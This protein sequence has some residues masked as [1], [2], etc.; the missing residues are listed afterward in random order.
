MDDE[1]YS[2]PAP[3]ISASD[4]RK[5]RVWR[6]EFTPRQLVESFIIA[7][8]LLILNG[9]LDLLGS[10][11]LGEIHLGIMFTLIAA[12]VYYV[13]VPVNGRVGTAWLILALRWYKGQAQHTAYSR[14]SRAPRIVATSRAQNKSK[15]GNEGGSR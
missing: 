5:M 2:V 12:S 6:A 13:F 8:L 10:G 11:I 1:K 9:I 3:I 15:N 14:K 7:M 4:S